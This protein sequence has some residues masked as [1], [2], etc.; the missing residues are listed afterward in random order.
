MKKAN[1]IILA[2]LSLIVCGAVTFFFI[3]LYTPPLD[4]KKDQEILAQKLGVRLQEQKYP[5]SFPESYYGEKLLPGMTKDQV[6]QIIKYYTR[7]YICSDW[8]EVYYYFSNADDKALRFTVFYDENGNYLHLS[9][10]DKNSREINID[11]CMLVQ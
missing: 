9:G 7:L 5:L 2:A 3:F 8:R 11:T 10:E 4:Y 6:H 1:W